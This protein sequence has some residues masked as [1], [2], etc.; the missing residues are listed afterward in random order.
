MREIKYRAWDVE[1]DKYVNQ[2]DFAIDLSGS[3]MRVEMGYEFYLVLNESY[4]IEQYT[5]VKDSYGFEVFE[6]DILIDLDD[7]RVY[8]VVTFDNGEFS[9]NGDRLFDEAAS[10]YVGGNIHENSELLEEQYA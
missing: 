3:L 4:V 9:V 2:D 8:G 7:N 5:G 10:A 6:G 1:T